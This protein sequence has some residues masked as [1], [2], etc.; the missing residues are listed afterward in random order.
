MSHVFVSYVREDTREVLRLRDDLVLAGI[1]V[2]LARE[3]IEPGSPW[4]EAIRRA[5]QTGAFFLAC[6]SKQRN[7]KEKTYMNEEL[8]LAMD[9]IRQRPFNRSW[10]IPL[11]LTPCDV[12][13]RDL[14][15]GL[16]L[17]DLQWLELYPDWKASV[18]RLI[19]V[20]EPLPS[21]VAGW[22]AILGSAFPKDRLS[23]A[24]LLYREMMEWPQKRRQRVLPL[25]LDYLYD[26]DMDLTYYVV[27]A[28]GLI[29]HP[30]AL[31]ALLKALD[32]PEWEG[33]RYKLVDVVETIDPYNDVLR[34]YR[35]R[36]R[37]RAKYFESIRRKEG[38]PD[39]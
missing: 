9:E 29:R 25:L 10:F 16:R 7:E 23:A 39:A 1:D 17:H 32:D 22:V 26:A 35:D 2:W 11:K 38:E 31:D 15:G 3:S 4:K 24:E 18:R 37:D 20:I 30:R 34:A 27:K 36:L 21:D 13:D 12:P 5:I 14:G 6:F 28:L 19:D 8:I 33:H